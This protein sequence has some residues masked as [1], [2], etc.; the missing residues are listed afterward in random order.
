M[1]IVVIDD[2]SAD[3][4][5][6]QAR[7]LGVCVVSLPINLG[8]GAALQTGYKHAVSKGYEYLV[9]MDSDGQHDPRFIKPMLQAV[10]AGEADIVIGSRF[11]GQCGYR[12]SRV[13]WIGV[14]LFRGIIYAATGL[15]ITD[16]TSGFQAMRRQ[17]FSVCA[18][19]AY[20]VDYP[21]A[22][23]IILLCRLG[24][25]VKEMPVTMYPSSRSSLHAGL[26]PVYYVFKMLLSILMIALSGPAR[27]GDHE[28]SL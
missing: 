3:D 15:R 7:D 19:A 22:D 24:L 14:L 28:A 27:H 1:D 21:D 11:L 18:S 25:T 20:P 13:R 5:A 9:Q 17:V 26:K 6:Q 4:T 12:F 16:P 23:V 8:Y 2:G 10:Q